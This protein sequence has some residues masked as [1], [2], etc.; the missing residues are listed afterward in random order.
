MATKVL[1]FIFSMGN[2]IAATP[3]YTNQEMHFL[4]KFYGLFFASVMTTSIVISTINRKFYRNIPTIPAL[5]HGVLDINMSLLNYYIIFSV[6]FWKQKQWQNLVKKLQIIVDEKC[7][8][9]TI[10][11]VLVQ[12]IDITF[13]VTAFTFKFDLM[14]VEYAKKYNFV[15][16]QDYMIFFYNTLMCVVLRIILLKYKQIYN[17][18]LHTWKKQ[19]NDK[20]QKQLQF[21]KSVIDNFNNVFGWPIFLIISYTTLHLL[22][23]L[24]NIFVTTVTHKL[25]SLPTKKIFA[26]ISILFFC[27]VGK[28][29]VKKLFL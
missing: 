21:L 16:V 14:G 25:G 12:I 13:L 22:C 15:Y 3:S 10:V 6:I 28:C 7:Y 18:L 26:D 29:S 9:T 4:R 19:T 8:S 23:H 17:L 20:I 27:L 5:E 24:D 2:I 11:F 1:R